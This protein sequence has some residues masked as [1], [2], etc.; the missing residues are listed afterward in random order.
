MWHGQRK[1]KLVQQTVPGQGR[2]LVA[3]GGCILCQGSSEDQVELP[4]QTVGWAHHLPPH[5][6]AL[7]PM[8]KYVSMTKIWNNTIGYTPSTHHHFA[9]CCSCYYLLFIHRDKVLVHSS[10]LL[11]IVLLYNSRLDLPFQPLL[12]LR[13]WLCALPTLGHLCT[14]T[15]KGDTARKALAAIGMY[16]LKV[17]PNSSPK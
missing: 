15:S 13:W 2:L 7:G 17:L 9:T 11:S 4:C 1:K 5:L 8:H 14:F 10:S 16:I 12:V 3:G 6:R